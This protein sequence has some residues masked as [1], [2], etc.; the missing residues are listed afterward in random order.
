[1]AYKAVFLDVGGVILRIDWAR[2]FSFAGIFDPRRRQE[3]IESFHGSTL[4]H[5]FE[6]GT[7]TP[8]AFFSGLGE[9]MKMNRSEE[10]WRDAWLSLILGELPEVELIFDNLRGRCPVYALSNTNIVHYEYQLAR[11]PILKRFDG[12]FASHEHGE[13]K[14]DAAFFLKACSLFGVEPNEVLFVDDTL[15]NVEGARRVGMESCRTVNSVGGT[16]DF[17]SGHGFG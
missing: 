13:R 6:K 11:F 14:P 15:E 17:L 8:G 4:F 3:L 5:R 1:M 12:I 10:F 7:I 9:L 2:P 16:L